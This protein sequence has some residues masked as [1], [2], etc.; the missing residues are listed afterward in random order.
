MEKTNTITVAIAEDH[1]IFRELLADSINK[2]QQRITCIYNVA[3]GLEL[4]M[5]LKTEPVDVEIL[6]IQMPVMSGLE[7]IKVIDKDFPLIKVIILSMREDDD[8]VMEFMKN[9]ANAFLPKNCHVDELVK[10][11]ESVHDLGYYF[12]EKF[13][14]YLLDKLI[15]NRCIPLIEDKNNESLSDREKEV[16]IL[17]CQELSSKEIADKL[18]ISERT[19]QN[20]RQSVLYKTGA[21][22]CLGVMIY[23]LQNGIVQLTASGECIPMQNNDV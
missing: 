7:A 9:G 19:A 15:R 2:N 22:N 3:N 1:T 14:K 8:I 23:A 11:I 5:R 6:D 12:T 16:T 18:Y 21:K 20:H 17:M 4:L 10:A 13:P